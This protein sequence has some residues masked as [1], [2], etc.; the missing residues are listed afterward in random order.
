MEAESLM[1]LA[2]DKQEQG[3]VSIAL[4]HCNKSIG[5]ISLCSLFHI[6]YITLHSGLLQ[7]ALAVPNTCQ[8]SLVRIRM[9]QN[10]CA[11]RSRTL[12]KQLSST[13]RQMSNQSNM[14]SDVGIDSDHIR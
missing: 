4:L 2:N 5:M 7:Q 11:M 3:D 9:K 14:S 13:Q 1:E 10:A 12:Q 8:E 6:S